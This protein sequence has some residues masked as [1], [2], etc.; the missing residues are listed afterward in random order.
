MRLNF[1]EPRLNDT[2]GQGSELIPLSSR[3]DLLVIIVKAII[4][5]NQRKRIT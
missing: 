4:L 2:V 5:K 1:Q 3:G